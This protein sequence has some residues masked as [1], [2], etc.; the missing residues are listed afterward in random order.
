M[1]RRILKE[2]EVSVCEVSGKKLISGIDI[3]YTNCILGS[4]RAIKKY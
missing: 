3:P 1:N 4:V 2:K